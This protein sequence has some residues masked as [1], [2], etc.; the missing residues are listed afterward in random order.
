ML[1][2][3]IQINGVSMDAAAAAGGSRRLINIQACDSI[4]PSG[5]PS[6]YFPFLFLLYSPLFYSSPMIL[7]Q[8]EDGG[9]MFGFASC[10]SYFGVVQTQKDWGF[11]P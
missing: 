9:N 4:P 1:A 6:F 7:L 11:L 10:G 5:F 8:I 2:A 3:L